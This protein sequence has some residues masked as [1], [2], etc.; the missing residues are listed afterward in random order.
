M[1]SS[2]VPDRLQSQSKCGIGQ[3]LQGARANAVGAS[4]QQGGRRLGIMSKVRHLLWAFEAFNC[5]KR[6]IHG[7]TLFMLLV[8]PT[9]HCAM[10]LQNT[11][12]EQLHLGTMMLIPLLA[13]ECQP[14]P[15]K[16]TR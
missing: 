14:R 11:A 5:K 2:G 16:V 1:Q 12:D 7:A 6:C 8:F 15:T 9:A 3:V 4:A 10:Q 13:Q